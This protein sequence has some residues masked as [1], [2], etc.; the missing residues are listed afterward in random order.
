MTRTASRSPTKRRSEPRASPSRRR[1]WSGRPRR[2]RSHWRRCDEA[3][4]PRECRTRLGSGSSPR[5]A[6]SWSARSRPSSGR[7]S[8]ALQQ[9]LKDLDAERAKDALAAAGR[10]AETA[11]RGAGAQPRALPARRPRGRSG[12]PEPGVE[13]AGARATGVEPASRPP[14]DSARSAL[15]ERQLAARADSLAAALQRVAKDAAAEEK[16]AAMQDMAQQAGKAS[17]QMQQAARSAQRGQRAPG[18]AAGRGGIALARTRWVTSCNSGG[19]R[20]SGS[21]A[22]RW[23][24]RSTRP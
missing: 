23:W 17:G 9:A 8:R 19:R 6:T 5:F 13:G 22:G 14:A 11:A 10:G 7:S 2:W 4:R 24:K 12:Q 15:A 18:E 21:G 3:P 20:C 16:P 1:S